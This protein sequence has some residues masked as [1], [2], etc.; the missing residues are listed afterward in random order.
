M[1]HRRGDR[2]AHMV[3][4]KREARAVENDENGRCKGDGYSVRLDF[5]VQV[6]ITARAETAG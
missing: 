6:V 5:G 1:I 3:S 2:F 4:I